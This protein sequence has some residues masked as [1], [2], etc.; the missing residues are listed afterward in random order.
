LVGLIAAALAKKRLRQAYWPTAAA[1]LNDA[2]PIVCVES[3]RFGW[4]VHGVLGTGAHATAQHR[5]LDLHM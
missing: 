3:E 2:A 5:Y 1:V 4:Q